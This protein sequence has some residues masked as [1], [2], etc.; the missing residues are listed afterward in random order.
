MVFHHINH[1]L[2]GSVN[3]SGFSPSGYE[4]NHFCCAV[5]KDQHLI[6]GSTLVDHWGSFT[7]QSMWTDCHFLVEMVKGCNN[8]RVLVCSTLAS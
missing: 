5:G 8:P 2:G 1:E 6:K 3:S 4:V 7:I